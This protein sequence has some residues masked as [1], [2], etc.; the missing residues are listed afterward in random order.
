[1]AGSNRASSGCR[2]PQASQVGLEDPQ[3][4][5]QDAQDGPQEFVALLEARDPCAKVGRRVVGDRRHDRPGGSWS[6]ALRGR[7]RNAEP[8]RD[9]RVAP[10]LDE[11]DEPMV[12]DPLDALRLHPAKDH[13]GAPGMSRADGTGGG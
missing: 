3:E 9:G 7:P 5:E 11:L 2:D 10:L 4:S 13:R 12:V 1:M 8:G 6:S